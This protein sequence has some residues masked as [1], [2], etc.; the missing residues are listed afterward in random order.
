VRFTESQLSETCEVIQ[1]GVRSFVWAAPKLCPQ[2]HPINPTW[3]SHR[4]G[5]HVSPVIFR[6][7]ANGATLNK[8]DLSPDSSLL[9]SDQIAQNPPQSVA[10][11]DTPVS[12]FA[13]ER[14]DQRSRAHLPG[15]HGVP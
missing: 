4:C 9:E 8:M 6:D 3:P 7:D 14:S 10:A 13:L 11:N 1:F 12:L 5:Y 2:D 15:L